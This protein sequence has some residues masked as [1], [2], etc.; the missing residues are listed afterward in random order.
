MT[1]VQHAGHME[2]VKSDIQ[3]HN[4][5]IRK[6]FSKLLEVVGQHTTNILVLCLSR[7]QATE[8]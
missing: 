7:P 2:A 6:E 4:Q 1:S 8:R 3:S 5:D